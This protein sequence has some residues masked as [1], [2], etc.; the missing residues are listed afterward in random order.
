MRAHDLLLRV[1]N[2]S[3]SFSTG[4]TFQ[5]VVSDVSFDVNQGETIGIVGESGSGKSVT[6]RSIMRLLAGNAQVHPESYLE[7]QGKELL[8]Q[9][10]K[11]MRT[12]RG[13]EIG[14]IFQDPM[15]S[16][17]PT[18]KIG[19]QIA[20]TYRFHQKVSR[21]QARNKAIEM[22]ELVGIPNVHT[23][24][25]Q[26]PHE[27]SG[28][29]RQ[30]IMIA[31]SLACNPKLLI[32]DEPTTALDVTIQAQILELLK[33]IQEQ[34]GTAILLITHDFGVVSSICDRV[35]VMQ[36]GKVVETGKTKEIFK[37]PKENYTKS[38][39]A[40]IPD[41]YEEK[42]ELSKKKL[43]R[44][45]SGKAK[46]LIEIKNL[47]KSF[48]LGR[49]DSIKAVNN[50][51]FDV[52]EG[53]TLGL[54]GESGSGKST[55]GRTILRLHE[56]NKGEVIY[57]GFDLNDLSKDEMTQMRRHLQIVFQDPYASLDPRKK[58]E[59]IIGEALDI[60][61]LAPTKIKRRERIEELLDLVGLD[62]SFAQRFPH[63]FS[64]GQRQRIGIARAL[65]VSPDFIVLDE[66]LSALDASIQSQIVKLLEDLQE[67]LG[68]TYL[69]IAHDL[70]MVKK[71]SDRIA[72][73]YQGTIVELADSEELFDNPIHAYTKKLLSAIPNPNPSSREEKF[74]SGSAGDFSLESQQPTKVSHNHWVLS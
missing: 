48:P 74:Y 13:K 14:M 35:V 42:N 54:V 17:N 50:L 1:N 4:N 69:F 61:Q 51:T 52:F 11:Q 9:T 43:E 5:Q 68:L 55:T 53:E 67:K 20:E 18:M 26:Y 7:F 44:I 21:K 63:E 66:P 6:A 33:D 19:S 34:F 30:R 32:A 49:N 62:P 38:L 71:L 27:F 64:G 10:E 60:H 22:M 47:S 3:V 8:N 25:S 37:N 24:Y 12:I 28:G 58:I 57:E 73:M 23:R 29:M 72:V 31:L 45:H 59:N 2:L 70:A 16:L 40:A 15:T 46:K 39:L 36:H 65:A 41:L 56:A